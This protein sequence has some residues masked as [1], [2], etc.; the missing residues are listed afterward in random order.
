LLLF[1][2]LA[3]IALNRM[4]KMKKFIVLC[5]LFLELTILGY[6]QKTLRLNIRVVADTVRVAKYNMGLFDKRN[7]I[8]LTMGYGDY[9]IKNAKE[10]KKLKGVIIESVDLIYTTYPAGADIDLL[11]KKRLASLYIQ[12]PEIFD[13]Y[14]LR[15]YLVAQTD[16]K[17]DQEAA[18]MFHGIIITYRPAA[19]LESISQERIYID[20]VI[21]GKKVLLDSTVLK[22]MDRNKDWKNMLVVGDFTGSM[23]PYIA[24]LLVWHSLNIK[25]KAVKNFVFFNDGDYTPDNLKKTGSTGGIYSTAA[26]NLDSVINTA[27]KTISNGGGGDGQENDVEALLYGIKNYPECDEVILIAD[28]WAPMRDLELADKITKPIRIILCGVNGRINPDYLELARITKGSVHTMEADLTN[29]IKKNE[30]EIVQFGKQK[31][32]VY[33]NKFIPVN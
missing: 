20:D 27:V 6:S 18:A 33:K 5:A 19:T 7:Q 1:T 2:S 17:T 26:G 11:N 31:F 15:W 22:V 13:V 16:C 12:Y 4:F 21:K 30:G 24:Q 9:E 29:L 8:K 32:R 23:S 28:N 3:I 10:L 25:K 14:P